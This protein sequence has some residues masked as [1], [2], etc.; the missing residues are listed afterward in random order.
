MKNIPKLREFRNREFVQYLKDAVKIY[1][2]NDLAKLKLDTYV[3]EL[4]KNLTTLDTI[5][6][7]AK[8]NEN[9]ETLENLDARRDAA[10]VGIRTVAEGYESHFETAAQKAGKLVKSHIDKYGSKIS[11]LN[12]LAETKAIGSVISDFENDD[13]VQDA[14]SLLN[15]NSWVNELKNANEAF[16]AMYL[17]RNKDIAAQPDQNLL[18]ARTDAIPVFRKLIEK[19]E[20]F[21]V[22]LSDNQYKKIIDELEALTQKYNESVPKPTAKTPPQA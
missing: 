8:K 6:G 15:I 17:T 7:V 21:Y 11:I 14:L 1:Q 16:N 2:A 20:A 10:I 12:Y 13:D 3:A 19:T 4:L 9:T 22:V 5:F 18:D